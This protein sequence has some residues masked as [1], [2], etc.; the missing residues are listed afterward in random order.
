MKA[1]ENKV[2]VFDN[3]IDV[4]YQENIKNILMGEQIYNGHEFSW[5]FTGFIPRFV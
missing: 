1:I 3:I 5:Y 2:F 4:Q